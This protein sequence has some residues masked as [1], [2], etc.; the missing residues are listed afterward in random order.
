MILQN[1]DKDTCAW[2]VFTVI[3]NLNITHNLNNYIDNRM[4][5]IINQIHT[6]IKQFLFV[7]FILMK[8]F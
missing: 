1:F 2:L 7:V 8:L 6:D 4:S 5:F 3:I